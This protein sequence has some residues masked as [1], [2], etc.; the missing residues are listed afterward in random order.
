MPEDVRQ[1]DGKGWPNSKQDSLVSD[2]KR[3]VPSRPE[4]VV[5]GWGSSQRGGQ[6]EC[7]DRFVEVE[8]DD[9]VLGVVG[10]HH[11]EKG[12]GHCSIHAT[13]GPGFPNEQ[14]VDRK[15]IQKPSHCA[16]V[17]VAVVIGF[18]DPKLCRTIGQRI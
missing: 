9:E 11:E 6:S 5:V 10:G 15:V 14:W 7:V 17:G 13:E 18:H 4:V 1:V 2:E 16:P 3:S 12:R 8:D